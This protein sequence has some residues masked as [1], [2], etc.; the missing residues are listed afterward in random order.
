M[1]LV[2]SPGRSGTHFLFSL[3]STLPGVSAYHEPQPTLS[4]YEFAQGELS[5]KE[6]AEIINQKTKKILE[7]GT[8]T[9]Y[10]TLTMAEALE[11]DGSIISLELD[12]K[13]H[14]AAQSFV[15]KSPWSK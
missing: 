8:F 2:L 9:A 3:C 12:P 4:S 6:S 11:K 5:M 15:N 13:S 14:A 1:I 7:I 10:A